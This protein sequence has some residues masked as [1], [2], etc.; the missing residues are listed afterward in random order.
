[1]TTTYVDGVELGNALRKRDGEPVGQF[2]VRFTDP[3]AWCDDIEAD[4]RL[5]AIEDNLVRLAVINTPA[6]MQQVMGEFVAGP[7]RTNPMY[8]CKFVEA[9]YQARGQLVKLSCFCG[10]ALI[11]D[12]PEKAQPY[13]RPLTEATAKALQAATRKVL[14]TL[15]KLPDIETRG[16]G[17]YVQD[18]PWTAWPETPIEEP[19]QLVCATCGVGIYW[20][21]NAWRHE[22]TRRAEAWVDDG[23]DGRRPRKK[24][25]HLADPDE[26]ERML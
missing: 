24:L 10:V 8:L 16:G 12:A 3:S 14:S 9:S 17:Y 26:P 2:E 6:S 21:N 1:M 22:D 5:H 11:A 23:M 18:G 4:Y 15:A 13:G 7:H 25:D 19:E 20:S